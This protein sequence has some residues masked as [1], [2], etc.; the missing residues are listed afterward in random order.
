MRF[1]FIK[2]LYFSRIVS[3]MRYQRRKI[4]SLDAERSMEMI[5][6]AHE[7]LYATNTL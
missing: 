2:I 5:T 4:I 7:S 6:E 1:C 3:Y